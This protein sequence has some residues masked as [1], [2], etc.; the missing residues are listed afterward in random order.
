MPMPP[1]HLYKVDV[2]E[3]ALRVQVAIPPEVDVT[4]GEVV[5]L[6]LYPKRE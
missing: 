1:R 2:P 6:S 5:D 3:W 4:P